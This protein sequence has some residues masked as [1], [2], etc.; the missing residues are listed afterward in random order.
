MSAERFPAWI[1]NGVVGFL[2]FLVAALLGMI[3]GIPGPASEQT[4]QAHDDRTSTQLA[5]ILAVQRATCVAARVQAKLDPS[6][7]LR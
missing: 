1:K 6:E 3:P 5:Q 2:M 7:C 4:L